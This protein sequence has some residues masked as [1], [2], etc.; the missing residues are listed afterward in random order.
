MLL[1]NTWRSRCRS[2]KSVR[3]LLKPAGSR[4]VDF[5]PI[6]RRASSRELA[7][8]IIEPRSG[9]ILPAPGFSRGIS[10]M[11]RPKAPLYCGVNGFRAYGACWFVVN[12]F[13]PPGQEPVRVIPRKAYRPTK[14]P[15][16]G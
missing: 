12:G 8:F 10:N 16:L 9:D 4:S 2:P 15:L 5:F 6:A 13:P 7:L 1:V 3:R 14:P 11:T